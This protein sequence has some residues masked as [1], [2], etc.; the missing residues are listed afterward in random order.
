MTLDNVPLSVW[1]DVLHTFP[2]VMYRVDDNVVSRGGFVF[3]SEQAAFM[4]GRGG[5]HFWVCLEDAVEY[6]KSR[7]VERLYA[8][9]RL[10]TVAELTWEREWMLQQPQHTSPTLVLGV[11]G[12]SPP[13]AVRDELVVPGAERTVYRPH[14]LLCITL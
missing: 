14:W 10:Q 8:C 12:Y 13:R 9:P 7:G 11:H 5:L 1:A 3:P 4:T 2:P 6:A